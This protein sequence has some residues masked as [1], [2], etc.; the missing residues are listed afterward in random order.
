METRSCFEIL[1]DFLEND[2]PRDTS[3]DT[4]ALERNIIVG[5]EVET[6]VTKD[7][8]YSYEEIKR[9]AL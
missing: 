2:N 1:K 5:E 9:N 3:E 6:V 4:P 8:E 7:I